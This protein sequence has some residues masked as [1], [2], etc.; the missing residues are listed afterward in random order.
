MAKYPFA[1]HNTSRTH[2]TEQGG[3]APSSM[4][5]FIK[6]YGILEGQFGKIE[7]KTHGHSGH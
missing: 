7:L 6:D 5:L 2:F 4:F 3:N 1:L